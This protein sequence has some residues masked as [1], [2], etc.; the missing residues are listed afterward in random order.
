MRDREPIEVE[1]WVVGDGAPATPEHPAKRFAGRLPLW[2]KVG[3]Q[4]PIVWWWF[5]ALSLVGL[6]EG[7]W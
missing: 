4:T 3:L 2:L 6:T 7:L 1:C 5:F